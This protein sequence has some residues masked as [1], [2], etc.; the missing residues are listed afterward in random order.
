MPQPFRF[1]VVISA[2]PSSAAFVTLTRA[3]EELG[4]STLL[5]PDRIITGLAV[6]PALAVAAQAT[7]SLRVGS[8]MFCNDF[9]HPVLLAR[10]TATLDFLS[11][12]R[13]EL[14]LGAGVG[15]FDYQRLGLRFEDA[16]TRVDRLEEALS[17]IKRCFTGER[18]NFTGRHFTI[19]EMRGSPVPVQ[20][21]HPPI[22]IGGAG[23]RM[24]SLAAREA[25]SISIMYRLPALGVDAP[26]KALEQQ[27]VWVRE[28]AGDRFARLELSQLAYVL[29]IDDGRVDRDFEGDGPPIPRVVM[30]AGQV[31]EHL[32]EQ[33]ERYGFSS[34]LVYGSVQME[35][36]APVVAQLAGR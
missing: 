8:Y 21:P 9:H 19:T 33:R 6:L 10:E 32:L 15:P 14:G 22:V 1:S 25:N 34:I 5:L 7:S 18:V 30:S 24:L 13:F 20:K 2:A 28:A 3:A 23:K 31:V 27:L 12:G 26:N 29:A 36:F 4:Y 17:V 35:N 11:D 16:G